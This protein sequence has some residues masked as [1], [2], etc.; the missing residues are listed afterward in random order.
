M[1]PDLK[2]DG[3]SEFYVWKDSVYM[4]IYMYVYIYDVYIICILFIL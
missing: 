3:V 2:Y 1:G 4:Y